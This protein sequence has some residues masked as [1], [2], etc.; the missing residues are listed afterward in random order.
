MTTPIDWLLDTVDWQAAPQQP[1]PE[2]IPYATHS[3][4][5]SLHGFSLRCYRLNDGRA[6]FDAD[7]ITAL[8]SGWADAARKEIGP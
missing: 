5:L 4:L 8:F 7:D 1:N 6:V 2:G 3:G